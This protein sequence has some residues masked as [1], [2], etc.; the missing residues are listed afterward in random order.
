VTALHRKLTVTIGPLFTNRPDRRIQGCVFFGGCPFFRHH[1][2]LYGQ[3]GYLW[4][5]RLYQYYR[6]YNRH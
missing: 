1:P 2:A 6:K 3:N 5:P 4:L